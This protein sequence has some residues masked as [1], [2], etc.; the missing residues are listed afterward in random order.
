MI[1]LTLIMLGS[2]GLAAAMV[3]GIPKLA[4]WMETSE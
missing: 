3:V 1:T 4:D 2:L